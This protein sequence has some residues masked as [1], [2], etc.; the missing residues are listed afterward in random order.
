MIP[1]SSY[2][3]PPL[4]LL[5]SRGCIHLAKLRPVDKYCKRDKA[6]GVQHKKSWYQ[7]GEQKQEQKK[8]RW[9]AKQRTKTKA[10]EEKPSQEESLQ[11]TD[12][13]TCVLS[14]WL[15][16]SDALEQI[17]VSYCC[18]LMD[19]FRGGASLC[20][21]VTLFADFQIIRRGKKWS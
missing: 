21:Q 9:T 5:L 19:G 15:N 11:N 6:E 14:G 1:N 17:K 4:F 18:G 7:E 20:C 3:P 8:D 13:E 16:Q 10:E 12:P 2:G